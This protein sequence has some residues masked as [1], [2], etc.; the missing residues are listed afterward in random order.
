MK[1]AIG[2]GGMGEMHK[3]RSKRLH[4]VGSLGEFPFALKEHRMGSILGTWVLL[5][6][7]ISSAPPVSGQTL[8][9]QQQ[10]ARDIYKDLVEINTVTATG[11]TGKAADAMAAP[12]RAAGFAE[13]DVQVFKPAP[14]KGNL[15]ARLHGSGERKPILLLAHMDVVDARREDWSFDPF[16]LLEKDGCFYARGSG[17]DKF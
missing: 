8:S 13:S 6:A 17:D 11:D 5:F 7:L 14:R 12:L 16:K 10:L 4:Q 9:A 1:S 15:V 2:A 3:T